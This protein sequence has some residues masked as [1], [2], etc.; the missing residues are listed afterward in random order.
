YVLFRVQKEVPPSVAPLNEIRDQVLTGWKQDQARADLRAKVEA[1]LKQGGFD[2]LKDL[3]ATIQTLTDT[4]LS[5]HAELASHSGI[6][7]AMLDTAAGQTTPAF[8]TEDGKLW[9]ARVKARTPAPAL[10]FQTRKALVESIQS[11]E[12]GKLLSAEQ[13]A[14]HS[15]GNLHP[16]FSSLWGRLDGIWINEDYVKALAASSSG[17]DN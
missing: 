15:S 11:Q 17:D 1:T 13:E 4:T 10:T 3:G 8:W 7:K 5:A 6:R 9:V 12:A 2:A 14:L 16:G